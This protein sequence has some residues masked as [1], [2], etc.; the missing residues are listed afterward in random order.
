MQEHQGKGIVFQGDEAEFSVKSGEARAFRVDEHTHY[1]RGIPDGVG[2]PANGI[3]R[4][5]PRDD[6]VSGLLDR[7]AT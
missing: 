2:H 7:M 1:P 4:Q 6:H 3:E 5:I